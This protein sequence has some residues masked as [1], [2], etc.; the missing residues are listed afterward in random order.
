VPPL[1]RTPP[2]AA[3]FVGATTIEEVLDRLDA[4]IESA[5]RSGSR[6]A[7]FTC[8]YRLVTRRVRDGIHSGRFEDGPRMERLDVVFANRYLA[9]LHAYQRN[10][11]TTECWRVTFEAARLG[12]LVILQHL[13]L[14]MNAHINLDLGIAAAEVAPG[15]SLAALRRDFDEINR[16]LRE[17]LDEVQDRLARVS[18]WM[19]L[20]DRVGARTDEAIC[21]FCISGARDLAWRWAERFAVVSPAELSAEVGVLDGAVTLLSVPIR[22]PTPLVATALAVVRLRERSDI[23]EVVAAMS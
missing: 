5:V 11:R 17:M 13:L 15:A 10:E 20:L 16:V 4:E 2:A 21:S 19:G 8:M 1:T 23:A 7:F 18:P 12:R 6:N 3:T 22:R 9:A 14:G